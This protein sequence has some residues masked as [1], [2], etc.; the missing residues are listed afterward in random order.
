MPLERRDRLDLA[1][2]AFG[3]WTQQDY[4]SEISLAYP[5]CAIMMGANTQ[6]PHVSSEGC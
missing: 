5:E 4:D 6:K 2:P 3:I 1:T